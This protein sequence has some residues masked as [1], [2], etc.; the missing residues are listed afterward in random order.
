MPFGT[1]KKRKSTPQDKPRIVNTITPA[2]VAKTSFMFGKKLGT[3]LGKQSRKIL[4]IPKAKVENKPIN[5]RFR[6]VR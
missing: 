6:G 3:F 5:T 2:G 4:Q 1:G